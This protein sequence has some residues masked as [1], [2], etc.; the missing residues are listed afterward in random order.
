MTCKNLN[1]K[2]VVIT[3][4]CGQVGKAAAIR[5]AELGA[6]IYIIVR[7]NIETAQ[8]FVDTLPNSHAGHTALLAS[9]TDTHALQLAV[10]QIKEKN[11]QCDLLINA[12]GI[13]KSVYPNSID[14]YSDETIDE[15]LITNVRGTI[16][17]IR[18]FSSLL[19]N[20]NDGLIVNITSAAGHRASQSN[21]IYGASK[22]ALEL[23]TKT[24]SQMFA[25]NVRV[26][27]VCPGMLE[28]ATSGAHKPVGTNE[29]I[30][31]TI[32]LKRVGTADD[33]VATI[34]ALAI[35]MKYVTGST[36]M[37]DGGRLA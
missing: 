30:A 18:E 1:G 4:G 34:E 26:V 32:P 11:N 6:R 25:P 29:K 22:I 9:I 5:F 31:A 35:T 3:G 19:K 14:Q 12:A 17:V 2:V 15:I 28:N 21:M 10:Q 8:K 16:A 23:V 7:S 20:S 37:L 13:T 36:I 33:V 24:T 27:S